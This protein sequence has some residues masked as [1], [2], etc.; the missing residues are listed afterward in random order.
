M[1]ECRDLGETVTGKTPEK[2]EVEV[3]EGLGVSVP[4]SQGRVRGHRPGLSGMDRAVGHCACL[5]TPQQCWT[6][7]LDFS[8]C[9]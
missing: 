5:T 4:E 2:H 6:W 1:V 3:L 9:H 7:G 8:H